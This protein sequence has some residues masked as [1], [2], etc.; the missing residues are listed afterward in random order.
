MPR[1]FAPRNDSAGRHPV[2]KIRMLTKTD[3]H[4]WDLYRTLVPPPQGAGRPQGGLGACKGAPPVAESSDR[5]S[6]AGT[7]LCTNE[8]QGKGLVPTRVLQICNMTI[9]L[10]R[11]AHFYDR[12]LFCAVIARSEAT[13]QSVLQT[14]QTFECFCK[15][16][17]CRS[18]GLPRQCAHWLAMTAFLN[19]C[20]SFAVAYLSR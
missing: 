14:P 19:T 10:S 5:S 18:N 8:V 7:C 15:I 9:G 6:W 4:N 11:H 13:R 20:N 3:S 12:V 17:L 1:R 2:I 16:G